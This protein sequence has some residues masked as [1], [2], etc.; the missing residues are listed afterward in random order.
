VTLTISFVPANP[1]IPDNT[2]VGSLIAPIVVA[3]SDGSDFT[4]SLGFGSNGSDGGFCAIS[5]HDVILGA[6]PPL[7][8][9]VQNC[10]ITAT[11]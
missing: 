7:G 10:T 11:Q 3:V 1:T 9:S 6:Q 8:A 4:G 2:P 5:G